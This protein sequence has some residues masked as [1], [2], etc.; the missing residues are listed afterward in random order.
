MGIKQ[1]VSA[2][3]SRIYQTV[4]ISNVLKALI[5]SPQFTSALLYRI[6]H[7]LLHRS[8][9]LSNIVARINLTLHGIDIDPRAQI[10]DGILF[11]HPGGVVIGGGSTLGGYCTLMGGVTI[12]RKNLG[13]EG[14]NG[15][16]RIGACVTFGAS[17]TVLGP[18]D[19]ADQTS[20]GANSLLISNTTKGSVW[21]GNPAR[22]LSS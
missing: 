20:I 7:L 16:P 21:A 11:Q 4:S 3:L 15:Y 9:F 17:S 19:V 12:G 5:V 2:D 14:L 13:N 8:R 6:S 1:A 22:S 10:D 18:I